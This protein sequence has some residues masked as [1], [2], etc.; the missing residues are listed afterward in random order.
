VPQSMGARRASFAALAL[1]LLCTG[2]D[3]VNGW[4]Q[5]RFREPDSV[6][7]YDKFA[8]GATTLSSNLDARHVIGCHL[9]QQTRVSGGRLDDTVGSR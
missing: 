8:S 3:G 5:V 9:T 1:A 4:T 7:K 6:R 2:M